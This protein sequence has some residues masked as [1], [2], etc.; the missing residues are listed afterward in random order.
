[1]LRGFLLLISC[2]NKNLRL[3]FV[4]P[5]FCFCFFALSYRCFSLCYSEQVM[6]SLTL[7]FFSPVRV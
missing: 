5:C 7:R 3:T 4:F 2:V 1:M 6:E